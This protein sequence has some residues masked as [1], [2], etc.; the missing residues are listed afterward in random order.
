MK[1]IHTKDILAEDVFW[2]LHTMAT[3]IGLEIHTGIIIASIPMV[4][5]GAASL[6]AKFFE[7]VSTWTALPTLHSGSRRTEGSL[8]PDGRAVAGS[9]RY[10]EL[11][12]S[13]LRTRD[14]V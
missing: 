14:K 11:P 1:T 12:D 7:R 4:Y 2:E 9:E 10:T 5:S 6:L 3:W 8:Q 13:E